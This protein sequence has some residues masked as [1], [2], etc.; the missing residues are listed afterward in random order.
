MD[1]CPFVVSNSFADELRVE[2]FDRLSEYKS[3][4]VDSRGKYRNNISGPVQDKLQFEKKHKFSICCKNSSSPGYT[5]EK[6]YQAFR[7][8]TVP[9][10]WR[11]PKVSRV[12]N[13]KA[14]TNVSDLPTLNDIVDY[15][16]YLNEN[17]NAYYA[18][19]REPI[20]VNNRESA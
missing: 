3:K 12:F 13:H 2:L 9:I 16:K 10:F 18:M 15:V 20:F 11:N 8:Q 1:F 19:L 17:N 6:P 5:T 14:F 7:A 4:R